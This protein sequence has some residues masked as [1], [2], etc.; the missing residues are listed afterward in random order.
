MKNV[1]QQ[2]Q[3]KSL[4]LRRNSYCDDDDQ[5]NIEFHINENVS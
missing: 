3:Q 1:P 4:W 5:K 2:R